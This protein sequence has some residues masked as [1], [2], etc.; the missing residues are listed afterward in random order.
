MNINAV[1]Q[2]N[3]VQVLGQKDGPALLLVQGFGCD[4][5]IWD[6]VLPY[7]TETYK[8]V[9]FDHVGT[10]GAAPDAYD[11]VRYA[12]LDGYLEDLVG[13]LDV[14]DLRDAT[15]VAHSIA[16]MMALGAS[17]DNPRIGQLVLL[18]TSP[19][20]LNHEGYDG[21]FQPED[22]DAVLEAVQANYPLWAAAMAPGITGSPAGSLLSAEL[23]ER[24]CRLDPEHVRDFLQMSF[25][26]DVRQLLVHVPVPTLILQTQDDPLTPESASHYM[27]ER[28]ARSTL[29]KL[30]VRGNMPHISAPLKTLETI[31]AH[32]QG[33]T[34]G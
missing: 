34:H 2:R 11:P 32:L 4:Q 24:I 8:V 33:L 9:L 6:R 3:N 10:G 7:F 13:I 17:V 28:L 26:S 30:D 23:T 27:H 22:I 18:C 15:I 21:G 5:V 20:Y 12:S 16:G 14:L 1:I 25:A 31:L 19:C 29:T